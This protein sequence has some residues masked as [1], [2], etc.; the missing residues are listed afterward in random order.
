[1]MLADFGADV[2]RIDRRNRDPHFG[3]TSLGAGKRCL[4]LDLKDKKDR[5]DFV[6]LVKRADVLLEP[7]RPGKMEDLGL[8]PDNLMSLNNRLIYTRL[9]G[10]GQ[11]GPN[12][13]IAGHDINYLAQV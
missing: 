11:D 4:Q 3:T 6:K 1:M 5:D 8:G 12:K 9:T 7:Y 10:W 13:S 2:V